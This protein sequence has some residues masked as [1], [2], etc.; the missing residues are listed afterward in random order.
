MNFLL[1]GGGSSSMMD[2]MIDK[3]NK[4]D[5]R[6]YLLTGRKEKLFS[7]KRV[8]ERYDFPYD[9][10]SV[11]DIIES[12]KPEVV[13]FMGA[14]DTNFDW[15]RAGRQENARYITSLINI[16]SACSMGGNGRFV[17][18][19]SQEVYADNYAYN[20]PEE[21][22]VKPTGG[23]K[24]I[25]VAQGEE[26]CKNYQ[27]TQGLDVLILRLDHV[28][29]VPKRG[30]EETNPCF[31][32]CL[33]GFRTGKISVNNRKLFSMLFLKDAIELAYKA[34]VAEKPDKILY[35]I[36]SMDE[37]SETQLGEIIK[38]QMKGSVELVDTT[39]GEGHRLILDGNR[40]KSE[41]EQKIF[42]NYQEGAGRVV[43]YIER[44]LSSFV[45]A[46]DAGGGLGRRTWRTVKAV[47]RSILP[48][49]ENLVCFIPFFLLNNQ[50][51]ASRYF[52]R[53]DF[54]L[55][56]V[57]L[58]AIVH[59]QQQAIV[60]ALLSVLGYFFR[61]TYDSSGLDVLLDYNTY[62]WT[63]QLFIVGMTVGYMRDRLDHITGEKD[64][65]I[66]Y[67]RERI[68]SIEDI[69]ESNVRMK[70]NFEAQLVNQRDSLGQI[71]QITSSLEKYEPEEV[72]F[73]AAEVLKRLMKS[74]DVA[75]Y[76]VANRSYARLFSSTSE[77]A[78]KLG[79]SIEYT[80]MEEMYDELKE[81]RVYI[82]K[83]MNEKYPLMVHAVSVEGEM[84][85]ILMLWSIP[86]QGMTL[87]EANRLT[88][89]GT[90]I[91]GAVVRASRYLEAL[92]SNRYVEGMNVL[93]ADAFKNLAKAFF[94]ARDKGLTECALLEILTEDQ[95]YEKMAGALR[96]SIRQT[97]Y[98]GILENGKV[99]VLLSNTSEENALSVVER[100]RNSGYESCPRKEL[101]YDTD[102]RRVHF[103]GNITG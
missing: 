99:Y 59:G 1:I 64:E 58:F 98:L 67:L 92:R 53:L 100:F 90:L 48:F 96:D 75:I 77:N 22:V 93:K 39:V 82:N 60:S 40:Y 102:E 14:Y 44:N 15:Y 73:Y 37:I 49:V 81:G 65:E 31:H 33:E 36:S 56:Y 29:G 38:S 42:V 70:Q 55:L 10:D 41:F 69:N 28:Y 5:H 50:A 88:I 9:D 51:S 3:L 63:A 17:Y 43:R 30:Q 45:K 4:C 11:K 34:V 61:Q 23:Y 12:V 19:S 13:L 79:N 25:A 24:S 2:A 21:E 94:D 72:L 84:K 52:E 46:E 87:A 85:L 101:Y 27:R 6:V 86:W 74:N 16:L 68:V 80:A 71:Y 20:V 8:F 57:L 66:R 54:Y 89:I 47:F 83:S 78:R 62:V 35:H 95:D 76:V 103:S 18:L 26:I 7:Y 32:M 97:D 91:E